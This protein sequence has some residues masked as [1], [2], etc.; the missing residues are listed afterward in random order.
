MA[1]KIKTWQERCQDFD[2]MRVISHQDIQNKM[3]EEINELRDVYRSL[4]VKLGKYKK[5][6]D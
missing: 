6:N 2:D 3:Q 1:T 4:A 5:Q